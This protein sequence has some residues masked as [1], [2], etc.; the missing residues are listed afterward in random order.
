MSSTTAKTALDLRGTKW[1]GYRLTA[2]IDPAASERHRR[3]WVVARE[4]AALLRDKFGAEKISAFGS[5][6]TST[7]LTVH[8]DI[9]LVVWGLAPEKFYRAVA[10]VTGLS[11]EFEFDIVDA[12]TAPA[13]LRKSIESESV[14]V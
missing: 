14:P 12:K 6:A 7:R 9:D 8:S 5:L 2:R 3:A 4:A 10:A 1:K 11:A 13:L